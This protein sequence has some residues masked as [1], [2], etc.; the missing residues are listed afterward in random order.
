M[1]RIVED[2]SI[3]QDSESFSTLYKTD[4]KLR[5][6]L[7]REIDFDKIRQEV[8]STIVPSKALSPNVIL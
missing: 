3:W 5:F 1:S 2:S 7:I 6:G 4:T 8:I